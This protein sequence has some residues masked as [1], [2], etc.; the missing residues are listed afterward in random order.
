MVY[1]EEKFLA[2]YLCL[3]GRCL[4]VCLLLVVVVVVVVAVAV[5]VIFFSQTDTYKCNNNKHYKLD[6]NGS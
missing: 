3:L 5:M 2:S 1:L 6:L 4:F